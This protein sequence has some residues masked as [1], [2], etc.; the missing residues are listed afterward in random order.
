MNRSTPV[1]RISYSPVSLPA[2]AICVIS[3]VHP[4]DKESLFF[5]LIIPNF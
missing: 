3:A 1:T 2:A 5:E 4:I